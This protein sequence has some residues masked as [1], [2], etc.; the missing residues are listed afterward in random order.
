[1]D[2]MARRI[3]L[4]AGGKIRP[5]PPHKFKIQPPPPQFDPLGFWV[6]RLKELPVSGTSGLTGLEPNISSVHLEAWKRVRATKIT[7]QPLLGL[8]SCHL[9]LQCASCPVLR[10]RLPKKNTKLQQKCEPPPRACIPA[11]IRHRGS[12]PER[13]GAPGWWWAPRRRPGRRPGHRGR[14]RPRRRGATGGP[15]GPPGPLGTGDAAAPPPPP[16]GG[17]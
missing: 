11:W 17:G 3:N 12:K 15:P 9:F 5:P 10:R 7:V 6:R 14:R 1:V 4:F 8:F 13:Q 16:R 2:G